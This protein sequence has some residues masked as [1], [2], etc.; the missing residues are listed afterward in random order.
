[1]NRWTISYKDQSVCMT[2]KSMLFDS[3]LLGVLKEKNH[4]TVQLD[5]NARSEAHSALN[6]FA[7]PIMPNC[8]I[9]S[10]NSSST[11]VYYMKNG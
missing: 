11:A 8:E 5:K 10:T 4:S 6:E 1:M 2:K 9:C 7:K 3:A